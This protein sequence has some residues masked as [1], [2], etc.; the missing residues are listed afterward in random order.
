MRCS[1]NSELE[2]T[3]Q[4]G[5][6]AAFEATDIF[7]ALF[8]VLLST[9]GVHVTIAWSSGLDLGWFRTLARFRSCVSE[10]KTR[11]YVSITLMLMTY[12]KQL[13]LISNYHYKCSYL[14]YFNHQ[15]MK[16]TVV[17]SQCQFERQPP[18]KIVYLTSETVLFWF[19]FFWILLRKSLRKF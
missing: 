18:T 17:G 13:H 6:G 2:L 8:I 12:P 5:W 4:F 9:I 7:A 3:Y 11:A 19:Q 10:T 15:M 14:A 16:I 1:C